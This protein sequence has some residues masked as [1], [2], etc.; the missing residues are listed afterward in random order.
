MNNNE[1]EKNVIGFYRE[2]ISTKNHRFESWEHCYIE[3]TN[4][5]KKKKLKP[6]KKDLLALHLAFYLASWGM[7][8]GSSFILQKDYKVFYPV[9]E[10]FFENKDSFNNQV[11]ENLLTNGNDKQINEYVIEYFKFDK[12]L[13]NILEKVRT[14][15]KQ[16]IS[17]NVSFTLKTK[18]ILGI[19][20]S[21]PAYD[22]FF[23]DGVGNRKEYD[24][25]K[26]YSKNGVYKIL[27][28][29]ESHNQ[30]LNSIKHKISNFQNKNQ[31]LN[32]AEYPIMKI[33]DMYFWKIGFDIDLKK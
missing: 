4:R 3:F 15:V 13:E 11:V 10:L 23:Q 7:Y 18:I 5:F 6:A 21:I 16:N 30:I 14:S 2:L 22:R 8:R 32:K 25:F 29:A 20:G 12:K 1:I 17:S 24:L 31:Y 28:F 19:Y 33:I 26:S 27:K 9:I